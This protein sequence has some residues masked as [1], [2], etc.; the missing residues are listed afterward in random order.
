M[1]VVSIE[2]VRDP[3]TARASE[4]VIKLHGIW[5]VPEN[6]TYRIERV[7]ASDGDAPPGWPNGD[8]SPRDMRIGAS[9]IELLIGPDVVDAPALKP[10]TP[11]AIAIPAIALREEL[12][13]PSLATTAPAPRV[14]APVA[15]ITKGGRR[16]AEIAERAAAQRAEIEQ[17]VAAIA[18]AELATLS[19]VEKAASNRSA[20]PGEHRPTAAADNGGRT[21][22]DMIGAAIG[23]DRDEAAVAGAQ[24]VTDPSGKTAMRA[25]ITS[26]ATDSSPTALS[27]D[28]AVAANG[29]AMSPR[30]PTAAGRDRS[31]SIS[32]Q[33]ISTQPMSGGPVSG[34][35]VSGGPVR[36]AP[37]VSAAALPDAL[38]PLKVPDPMVPPRSPQMTGADRTAGP[39]SHTPFSREIPDNTDA[40]TARATDDL[41]RLSDFATHSDA[42]AP[43]S[44]QLVAIPVPPP[45][46][47]EDRRG[48]RGV[49]TAADRGEPYEVGAT[50]SQN[51]PLP[52][53]FSKNQPPVQSG[54]IG[55]GG[56]FGLGFLLAA[57]IAAASWYV[58]GTHLTANPAKVAAASP[59]PDR[60]SVLM[61]VFDLP[62][63]SPRGVSAASLTREDAL[64]AADNSLANAATPIE[65]DEA[66]YWLRQSL[67]MGIGDKRSGWAL[68]QLGTLYASPEG[69]KPDYETARALWEIAAARGDPVSFCFLAKLYEHGLGVARDK[70]Q[71]L[72]NFRR[73][74]AN[75]GCRD[76]DTA[77][78]R[79]TR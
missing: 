30:V 3:R 37:R 5:I 11:I 9:G 77:I 65:R 23:S 40:T 55:A 66:K 51:T 54:R 70:Q 22:V 21:V 62:D 18:A 35:P 44:Q 78:T 26:T 2:I 41:A 12:K 19:M 17:L 45:L 6:P 13:W 75:G 24:P 58:T 14:P 49:S 50:G 8:L 76:V 31:G 64:R 61:A 1:S 7:G 36:N 72:V 32:T 10:G 68:T 69:G 16:A 52:L 42:S 67:A 38:K 56:A 33:P 34:G 39:A 27:T 60:L 73:A 47:A 43:S 4:A 71:A 28:E 48:G 79:L 25:A 74:R 63:M 59:E 15:A 29:A 57:A 46:P 53:M 20:T